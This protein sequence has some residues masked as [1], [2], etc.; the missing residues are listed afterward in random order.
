MRDKKEKKQSIMI[1]GCGQL[2]SMLAEFLCESD[3]SVTVVDSNDAAFKK[4]SPNFG[5]FTICA[6]AMDPDSLLDADIKNTDVVLVTT[7]DDNVN[8]FVAQ[9]AK[10]IFGVPQVIARLYDIK[11]EGVYKE[12]GI[13]TICPSMLSA[14]AFR[15]EVL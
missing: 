2:G 4:L 12:F 6:D 15:N 13:K 7:D 5:G 1:V 11:R 10:E 3:K 9:L 8:I 14:E